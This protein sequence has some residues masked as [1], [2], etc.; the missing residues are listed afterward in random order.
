MN[1]TT[2]ETREKANK[3]VKMYGDGG[4]DKIGPWWWQCDPCPW[5]DQCKYAF[6]GYHVETPRAHS[7]ACLAD[8]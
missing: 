5:V 8:K 7:G 1:S 2:L 4:P 3:L 6:D